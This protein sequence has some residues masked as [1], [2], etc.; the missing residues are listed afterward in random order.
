MQQMTTD[1]KIILNDENKDTNKL[2]W[3]DRFNKFN[4]RARTQLN[5]REPTDLIWP[6]S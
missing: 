4:M 5:C 3:I 1:Q 6:H 2:Y